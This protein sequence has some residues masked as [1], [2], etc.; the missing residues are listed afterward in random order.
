MWKFENENYENFIRVTTDSAG[1]V[2]VTNEN[3]NNVVVVLDNGERHTEVLTEVDGMNI[4]RGIHFDETEN[5]LLVCNTTGGMAFL[6][7]VKYET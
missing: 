6:F 7:D 5:I 2:Y 4:P 1:N 3:T